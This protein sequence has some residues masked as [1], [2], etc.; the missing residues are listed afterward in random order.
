[1]RAA[2]VTTFFFHLIE[3]A[4]FE[5]RSTPCVFRLHSSLDVVGYLLLQ[6]EAKLSI[7]MF[8]RE[9]SVEEALVP[10]HGL[11]SYSAV[12]RIN[13]TAS[14]NCSQFLTSVSNCFRPLG[15]SA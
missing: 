12:R 11:A 7:E 14:I 3:A 1:M 5:P 15:V 13:A 6:M 2:H 8:L 10:A 9:L 4:E